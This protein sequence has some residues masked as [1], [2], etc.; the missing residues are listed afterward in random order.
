MLQREISSHER[1]SMKEAIVV[2]IVGI[3]LVVTGLIM[4]GM[5]YYDS[6]KLE[7]VTATVK[8]SNCHAGTITKS[9]K[10]G[11]KTKKRTVNTTLCDR[12]TSYLYKGQNYTYTE[13]NVDE[14]GYSVKTIT[15]TVDPDSPDK[16]TSYDGNIAASVVCMVFGAFFVIGGIVNI[17]KR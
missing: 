10:E 1:N 7:E 6:Q 2:L 17:K 15:A 5:S 4:G 13:T 9:Y 14:S 12:T 11:G 3:I 16:L 8:L